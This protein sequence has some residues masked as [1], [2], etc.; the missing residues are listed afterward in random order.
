MRDA[1]LPLPR[2][3]NLRRVEP[4]S[5]TFGSDRGKPVDRYYLDKFLDANR[6]LITGRVL[7]VQLPSYTKRFGEG[8]A[9]SHTVDIN[10]RFQTTYTCDLADGSSIP[11]DYYDCFLAPNT[12][13]HLLDLH[14]RCARCS[15]S[16]N[17]AGRCSRRRPC[18]SR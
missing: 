9:E 16:S 15:A 13:Q 6:A 8:V 18:C 2:W 10:P 14:P 5:K 3:G 11:S 17:R 7:E 4:F 1:G 12:L